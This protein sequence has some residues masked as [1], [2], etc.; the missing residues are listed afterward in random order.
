MSGPLALDGSVTIVGA[1]LAG[2]RCA[3]TLRREG[4][5]G[6][7]TMVGDEPHL[8]YD[9]PPLSKQVLSG[10]WPI[11]KTNLADQAK[12]DQ[13]GVTSRF[14]LRATGLDS[15]TRRVALADGTSID[16]DAVVIA[17]GATLRRLPGTESLDGVF[18]LRTK[19]DAVA[20]RDA[21][22]ALDPESHVVLV[23]A[24]FIGQEVATAAVAAGHQVTVLEGLDLP[25]LPIVGQEVAELLVTMIRSSGA[26]LL[27]GVR[28]TGI[29]PPR[30]GARAGLVGVEGS[31]AIPADLIVVGI[32]VVPA[33][34]WLHDSG[35]SIENGVVT[36][37]HLFAGPG[38]VAAGDVARFHWHDAGHDELVRIEHWQMAV[39]HGVHAA[40]SLLAGPTQAEIFSAV[41]YFWSDQWGKKIQVLGHPSA[42]DSVEI[43][44]PPDEDGRFIAA[45]HE[46]DFL[47]AVLSVSKPR[48][49]MSFRPLLAKGSTIAEAR[50]VEL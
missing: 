14:G 28:V 35:L 41:P 6:T 19:D 2:L 36:D 16:S 5:A 17:T 8:P 38:V 21:L 18:G 7:I 47:T 42:S 50:A 37:R 29:E 31:A 49:L 24:G 11:E 27:N 3:E 12:L 22:A 20:L 9:R 48:Q 26:E 25:L 34:D 13:L 23:G 44:S 46:G 33:T 10:T 43:V 32:G 30:D 40:R 1:S 4:F 39:D 45:F 15:T